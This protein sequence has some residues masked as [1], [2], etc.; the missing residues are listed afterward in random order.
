MHTLEITVH[1]QPD[2]CFFTKQLTGVLKVN[3]RSSYC[4]N[5]LT[6]TIKNKQVHKI[7]NMYLKFKLY[8]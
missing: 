8:F 7:N 3:F 1:T 5:K 6:R 2:S 4:F